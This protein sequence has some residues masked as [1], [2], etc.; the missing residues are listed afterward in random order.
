M[1]ALDYMAARND[2]AGLHDGAQWQ[3]GANHWTQSV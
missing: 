1:T 2:G 3:K